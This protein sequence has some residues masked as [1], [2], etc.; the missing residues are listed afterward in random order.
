MSEPRI[1]VIVRELRE[2]APRAPEHLRERVRALPE[3]APRRRMQFRFR[4]ALAAAVAGAVAI[5]VGAA[6]LDG[7]TGSSGTPEHQ[8][9]ERRALAPALERKGPRREPAI[10]QAKEFRSAFT[11]QDAQRRAAGGGAIPPSSRLQDYDAVLRLRVG[12]SD[13][14]SSAMQRAIR[15][16]R[17]LGGYIVTARYAQA[18]Q[19]DASLVVRVPIG[20]VQ[21]ALVRF[22]SL[23]TILS[24]QISLQDLQPQADR[25]AK[26]IAA[27]HDRIAELVA[28]RDRSGLTEAERA[29][30]A[31]QRAELER[32]TRRRAAVLH[33][34][35]YAQ[36]SLGLTTRKAAEKKQ[37]ESPGAFRTFLDDTGAIFT[38]EA[39]V[40][41][42]A[43]VIV[44]PFALLAALALLGER[45]RRR[46]ANDHLLERVGQTG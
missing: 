27:R 14:L 25:L 39:I 30:L 7:L 43:L 2:T 33:E 19:G 42:Y 37:D 18:A 12:D 23:G 4:P 45:A 40:L 10:P 1:D 46:R 22:S 24:Q 5:A 28:K 11:A 31:A 16:T 41:L 44:G 26:A 6:A 34:G 17:R 21:D 8:A 38:K 32:L 36:V 35:R 15:E 13:D 9:V 20:N 3:P 29:E